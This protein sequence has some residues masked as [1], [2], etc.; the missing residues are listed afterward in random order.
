MTEF[1]SEW[2]AQT[3]EQLKLVSPLPW[4]ACSCGK[5]GQISNEKDCIAIATRGNWGDDYPIIK[6]VGGSISGQY[7]VVME[8]ITYGHLPPET[9]NNNAQYIAEAC[10]NYPE[11]I[12]HIERLQKRIAELE[13]VNEDQALI[14]SQ[15]DY[16]YTIDREMME[17][18]IKES[19]DLLRSAFMIAKRDGKETNWEAWHN[20][21]SVAL[22]RQHKMIYG[23]DEK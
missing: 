14:I 18:E 20:K 11:A 6:P 8:Q 10:T 23:K 16:A 19:N 22:A 17:A 5:C 21:L 1:S 13:A 15:N 7:E 9:G 2:I 12:D 3:R 4:K